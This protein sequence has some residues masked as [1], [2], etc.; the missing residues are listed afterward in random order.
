MSSPTSQQQKQG[1]LQ[2]ALVASSSP[3]APPHP[4]CFLLPS[5]RHGLTGGRRVGERERWVSGRRGQVYSGGRRWPGGSGTRGGGGLQCWRAGAV[6]CRRAGAGLR[7][8]A[9]EG[10]YWS[11][12]EENW[13]FARV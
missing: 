10:G 5:V 1:H 6:C 4:P 3:E 9:W 7:S 8:A 2:S 11:V 12:E 13:R